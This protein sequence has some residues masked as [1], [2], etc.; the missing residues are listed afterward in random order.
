MSQ[1]AK[2]VDNHDFVNKTKVVTDGEILIEF[3]SEDRID[4]FTKST[5]LTNLSI[6]CVSFVYSRPYCHLKKC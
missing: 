2:I 4:I 3:F 1:L 6:P 5:L